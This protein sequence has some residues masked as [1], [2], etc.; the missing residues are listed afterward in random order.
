ML[1]RFLRD[2]AI[3]GLSNLLT[4]G[5]G[6]LLLPL[7]T[8]VLTPTQYG[9]VDLL[10]VFRTI[11]A[12]TVALEISQGAVRLVVDSRSDAEKRELVSTALWFTVGAYTLFAVVSMAW[13]GPLSRWLLDAPDAAGA[14]RLAVLYVVA[15]GVFG[16]L[17]DLLRF[18]FQARAYAVSSLASVAVVGAVTVALLLGT[19]LRVGA[20]FLGLTAGNLVGVALAARA[21]RRRVGPV[22]RWSRCRD[23]LAFSIPLVVSG[24]SIFVATFIDRIAIRQ[25]MT[26]ADVGVF[27]VGA[28]FASVV[29][30]GMVVLQTALT[31]L[32]YNHY[33]EEGTPREIARILRLVAALFVPAVVGL[34]VFG[35][36]IIAGVTTPE[37]LAAAPVLPV[38]A[39]SMALSQFWVFAPG[40][41]LGR[42]TR[43]IALLNVGAAALNTALNYL[44]I[45]WWGIMGAA[46]ATLCGAVMTAAGYVALGR[47]HYRVPYA[48]ARLLGAA[49]LGVAAVLAARALWGAAPVA[50]AAGWA[51][52]AGFCLAAAAGAA[53]LLV[54]ADEVRRVPALLARRAGPA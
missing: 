9:M 32:V 39:A 33:T 17:Q 36:E 25:L 41:G 43:T 2:S 8:R 48:P 10:Q 51:A 52:K 47:R 46:L 13:A 45:P 19:E 34:A 18:D 3:Y 23:M 28:R 5:L 27:G 50:D 21:A 44:L 54:S 11:V 12:L 31:P 20:I 37:Y 15:A 26:V 40:L 14:F 16:L 29:S 24:V 49:G 4:R 1:R 35:P 38:L 6:L 30:L 7:Y 42:R 53:A 22:F